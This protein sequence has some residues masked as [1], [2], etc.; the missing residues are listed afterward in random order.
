MSLSQGR[1]GVAILYRMEKSLLRNQIFTSQTEQRL[2]SFYRRVFSIKEIESSRVLQW[3][4]GALLFGFYVTFDNWV[5]R[6]G[7]TVEAFA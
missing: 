1:C 2:L 6:P 4:F 3:V 7:L 5:L